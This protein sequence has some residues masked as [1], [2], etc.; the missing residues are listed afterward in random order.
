MKGPTSWIY[1]KM[2]VME[3]WNALNLLRARWNNRSYR[4]TNIRETGIKITEGRS[5]T[6]SIA[7]NLKVRIICNKY[8]TC[9][10]LRSAQL[11]TRQSFESKY[12]IV[13]PCFAVRVFPVTANVCRPCADGN[14]CN[15]FTSSLPPLL[16]FWSLF[17]GFFFL[18]FLIHFPLFF[19]Y[20]LLNSILL[21]FFC[22]CFLSQ[23]RFSPVVLSKHLN[24]VI[25]I[26]YEICATMHVGNMWQYW[27][28][29][30]KILINAVG[31]WLSVKFF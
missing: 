17:L 25:W 16:L 28:S 9:I 13:A 27:Y 23:N 6:M 15:L 5:P 21:P 20:L 14:K 4:V 12:W 8:G 3:L 19:V 31:I 30:C 29:H 10:P 11:E 2:Q 26:A 18:F 1:F 22:C 24:L 7:A